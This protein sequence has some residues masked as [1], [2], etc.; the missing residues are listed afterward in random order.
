MDYKV[1]R[2]NLEVERIRLLVWG[3][4]VGLS[5][6]EQ[7]KPSPDARLNREDVRTVILLLG[8]SRMSSNT[9]SGCRTVMVYVPYSLL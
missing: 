5:K 8:P 6:V 3:E 7:G 1:L 9:R 4:A 2:V